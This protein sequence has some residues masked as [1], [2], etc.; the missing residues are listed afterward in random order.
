[1]GTILLAFVF[2]FFA[3]MRQNNEGFSIHLLLF[4]VA[5]GMFIL[6]GFIPAEPWRWRLLVWGLACWGIST[7]L[8][9]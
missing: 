9:F 3:Q 5:M 4:V 1:M 2:M 6:A 7:V 8:P